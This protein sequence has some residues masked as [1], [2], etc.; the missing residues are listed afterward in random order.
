MYRIA[1]CDDEEKI[2]VVLKKYIERF[3]EETGERAQIFTF[4][5]ANLLLHEYPEGLDLIFMDIYM[6]NLDGMTAARRIRQLD[7]RVCLLFITTMHQYALEGYSV[8][9]FGFIKKP[10]SYVEFRHELSCAISHIK[11]N[12]EKKHFI[13]IKS[14]GRI[15]SVQVSE[16]SYCEVN[17]HILLIHTKKMTYEYRCQLKEFEK[18][19]A[20]YGFLRCHASFLVNCDYI[21]QIEPEENRLY[22]EDG[23]VIPVSQSRKKEFMAAFSRHMGAYI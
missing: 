1:I 6:E 15:Y 16:I 10:V 12:H 5:S 23:S 18:Q 2:R 8:R 14:G 9:A 13:S 17:N 7:E 19:L 3:L 21:R 11:S 22:L 20:S 4:S